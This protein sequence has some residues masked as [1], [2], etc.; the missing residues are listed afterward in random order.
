MIYRSYPPKLPDQDLGVGGIFFPTAVRQLPTGIYFME[1]CLAGLFFLVRDGKEHAACRAQGII[2]I[3][4]V[5]FTAL[6]HYGL[7]H[8]NWLPSRLSS[9]P[10]PAQVSRSRRMRSLT[11]DIWTFQDGP[12]R[13]K[14]LL[15]LVYLMG[16]K[17]RARNCER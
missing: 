1:L 16:S 10:Q 5:G 7:G 11:A 4:V 3:I 2:M 9:E 8:E 13:T 6:F 14:L 15:L 17:E 12:A